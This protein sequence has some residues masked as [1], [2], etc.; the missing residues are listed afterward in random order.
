MN[1]KDLV[2]VTGMPGI[3]RITASRNNGM[4]VEDLD[5]GK[6]RFASVRKHQFSPLKSISIYTDDNDATE[7]KAVLQSMLDKMEETPP[8]APN[9]KP[10][11][12]RAYFSKILPNYDRDQVHI[13]D[14]KKIIRWFNFLN[15]RGFLTAAP[16]DEEE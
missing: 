4:M 16:A 3:Q 8:V 6:V 12:L 14:I 1:I 7:L 15:D 10:D 9:S 13:S 5:T 11:E 2:V